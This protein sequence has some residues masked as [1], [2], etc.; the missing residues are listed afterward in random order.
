MDLFK[1]KVSFAVT[2]F[3][4]FDNPASWRNCYLRIH[5]SMGDIYTLKSEKAVGSEL[6]EDAVNGF[7]MVSDCLTADANPC[8]TMV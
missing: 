5:Y 6:L 7:G 4:F 1:L 2:K 8:K 3:A